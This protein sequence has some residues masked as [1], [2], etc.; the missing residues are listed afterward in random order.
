MFN[1]PIG[2]SLKKDISD[3]GLLKSCSEVLESADIKFQSYEMI[4]P[5]EGDFVFFDP[6]YAPLSST[7]DFTSYTSEG[8]S[9]NDQMKLKEF[10]DTLKSKNV[11]FMLSNSNCEFI[12]ELYKDYEQHTFSLNRTLNSKKELRKQTTDN[13]ILIVNKN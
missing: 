4:N 6:P 7:S 12:R 1:V 9:L 11:Q 2:T 8:F 3:N 10:C 5:V 13:E